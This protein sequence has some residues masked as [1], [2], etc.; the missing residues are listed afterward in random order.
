MDHIQIKTENN[1][2]VGIENMANQ[3]VAG[4]NNAQTV[5]LKDALRCVSEFSGEPGTFYAF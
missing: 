4:L 1:T 3:G 5:S 2:E